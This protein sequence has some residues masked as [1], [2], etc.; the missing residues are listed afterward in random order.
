MT[1]MLRFRLGPIP[2][3]V[4]PS[5]F[6]L[7]TLIGYLRLQGADPGTWPGRELAA[8]EHGL[9]LATQV[10]VVAIWVTIVFVSVLV[11]E[12]GHAAVSLSFRYRPSITLVFLGGVTAPHAPGPIP[13]HREVLL[14]LAGPLAGAAFGLACLV[15]AAGLG[16]SAEVG[17]YV[18]GSAAF[19]NFFWAVMNLMPVLPLDGGRIVAALLNRAFGRAGLVAAQVLAIGVCGG[20]IYLFW[21]NP[22]ITLLFAVA[23]LQAVRMLAA[24]WRG[25]EASARPDELVQAQ[26]LYQ[27]GQLDRAREL[28]AGVVAGDPPP[29]VRSLAHHLLGWIAL[30]QGAGRRALDHFSQVQGPLIEPHALAAAFSLVG[31]DGKALP[32]W[33]QAYAA[34]RDPT[35]LHEW[36]GAL[37][38]AG[39]ADDASRIPGVDVAKA[40]ACAARVAFLRGDFSR[41][42]E[43]GLSGLD[44]HPTAEAAYDAACA[45]ARAGELDRAVLLLERARDLG[46]SDTGYAR[47]DS[48][49]AA[50]HGHPGFE[51]WL[52]ALAKSAPA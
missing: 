31:D 32:L 38:R 43:L 40:Y 4:H 30:K 41:A 46:F 22:W 7:A 49:L 5:H 9:Q 33:Q 10:A 52:Q 20:V 6:L 27:A 17:R 48:D 50:L 3:E 51:R 16:S 25:E 15:G 23:G 47:T 34:R 21:G 1:G 35:I 42:A 29:T 12:L 37:I 2:V 45:L 24:L 13:W 26:A 11:H 19:A 28:A 39:R 18:L 36:A 8:G 14:T 44:R